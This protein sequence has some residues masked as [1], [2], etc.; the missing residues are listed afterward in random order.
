VT[1]PTVPE[2]GPQPV[3]RPY[4]DDKTVERVMDFLIWLHDCRDPDMG[5]PCSWHARERR[6]AI[7]VAY[8]LGG[9]R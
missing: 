6:Q 3:E 8:E 2:A 9:P 4:P 1:R 7:D 5:V